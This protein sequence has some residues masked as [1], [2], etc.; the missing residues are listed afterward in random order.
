MSAVVIVGT[1]WG[2]EGKGKITDYYAE[3]SDHIVRFQGGNNAG[4]TIELE[5]ETFKLHLLPSGILRDDKKAVIG[6]GVVVDPKVLLEEINGLEKRGIDTSNLVLSDRAALIMPYHKA[7]DEL[8][9]KLKGNMKAGTTKKGIGPCY[10]DKVARFGIRVIDLYN[11]ES[12]KN[13]LETIVPIKN[14][15]FKSLGEN[16][17]WNVEELFQTYLKYGKKLEDYVK[18]VSILLDKAIENEERI[19]FEGAQG[20]HLDIDHGVYPYTTSSNTTAANA[21]TGSGIGPTNIESVIGIM[22]AYTSR[23]GTGP[24]PSEL[25]DET[26]DYI[27]ENGGEYGTTTGRPRRV[28]WLDLVMVKYS[29]RVNSLTELAVTNVDVLEDLEKIKICTG[30]KH[31]G[32]KIEEFPADIESM[33]EY[34]PIYETFEGWS[35]KDWDTIAEKGY[36]ALPE[37]I[38]NY[39][40]Y[41]EDAVGLPISH[42]SIGPKRHQTITR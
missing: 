16:N 1:Q 12:L 10:S 4:H 42:I 11:P 31:N 21:S 33:Y 5:E 25:E 18:D 24:F 3:K 30:Y 9:E 7:M 35:K 41:I 6:N 17:T 37:N 29:K 19:L 26:G 32:E 40:E 28:G 14:K 8:E 15:I 20:T 22:K 13:K 27:R 38:K 39:L 23:V 34:E 36:E 2:D